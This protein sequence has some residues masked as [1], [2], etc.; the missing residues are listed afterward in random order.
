MKKFGFTLAEVLLTMGIVG[1]VAAVSIPFLNQAMPDRNKAK[2]LKTYNTITK[3]NQKLLNDPRLYPGS[4]ECDVR[5]NG[6][7]CTAS[8]VAWR[9]LVDE[10]YH[11]N[12]LNGVIYS[13]TP[14]GA[15]KKYINLL[16]M[17]LEIPEVPISMSM[18]AYG[19]ESANFITKDGLLWWIIY[20]NSLESYRITIDT[21]AISADNNPGPNHWFDNDHQNPDEFRFLVD[22]FGRVKGEDALTRAYLENPNKLNDKAHDF[23]RAKQLQ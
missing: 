23:A 3:I 4:D 5:Q 17:N 8:P 13:S 15:R 21:N 2:V 22:K 10:R 19:A 20:D 12:S 14:L 9:D 7:D 11:N 1:I 6:F 16:A 18:F